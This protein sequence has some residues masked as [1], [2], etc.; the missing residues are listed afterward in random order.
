MYHDESI[1]NS[2]EGQT[3]VWGQEKRPVLLPK[4]K[5]SGMMVSD[6]IDE[7]DGYL[8]L[9]D[10]QFSLARTDNSAISQSAR[11][12]FEYGS[13]RGGY[14]T[15]ERFIEQVVIACDIAAIKY[16]SH[17][18]TAVFILDQSRCH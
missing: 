12:T 1:Y 14:W 3:W 6:F 17:S 10:A 9:T 4:T 5:G 7:Y 18:H 16:P 8:R 13:E 2:N 15:G 11:V